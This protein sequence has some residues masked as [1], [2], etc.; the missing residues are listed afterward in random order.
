MNY[1]LLFDNFNLLFNSAKYIDKLNN[2]I[3]QMAV[4]GKLVPQDPS[5]EPAEELLKE[6]IEFNCQEAIS[7]P[8]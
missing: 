7:A 6:A 2:S 8:G 1:D 5:D 4:Q 3:L